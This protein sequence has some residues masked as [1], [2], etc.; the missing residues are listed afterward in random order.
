MMEGG[1]RE[2]AGRPEGLTVVIPAWNEDGGI[3]V[4]LDALTAALS[5]ASRPT[6]VIV[7]DDGSTDRTA[8]EAARRGA[9]VI[10]HPVQSGYGASLKTGIRAARHERIAI[11]DADA[12]YPV[13]EIPAMVEDLD[14]FDLVVGARTGARYRRMAL[15][16]P[17][18]TLFLL[19]ASFVAGQWI[20]DPNS[21]LRAFRRAFAMRILDDLPRAFSFT[22][23]MTLIAT[24]EG[25]FV[26][27][28]PVEYRR[29]VGRRKVR[30][31]RDSLRMT[32]T[33]VEVVLRF[34]PLKL[35]LLAGLVPLLAAVV[36][37]LA[38]PWGAASMLGASYLVA[39]AVVV[40]AIG[41]AAYAVA[42]RR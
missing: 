38:V 29:R 24:L 9:R 23:T 26:R 5:G 41:M 8:A 42:R 6:E 11:V 20:P 31:V 3:G 25:A 7:V 13:E 33:V 17:L 4:T 40:F 22:T 37:L 15:L 2:E 34:N 30:L 10:S 28:R 35:F 36:V 18:R 27:Y 21:G 39:F 16:S 32:Q 12:T 19:I 1:A 14:R